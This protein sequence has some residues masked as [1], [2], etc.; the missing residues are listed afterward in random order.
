MHAVAKDSEGRESAK[1]TAF[2]TLVPAN[3]FIGHYTP[4][5]G[6]TVG[7]GMP[8]SINFTR[9]ITDPDAVEKGIKVTHQAVEIEGHWFG[10][11]RLDFRPEK[12]WKPGTEVTV[13]LNLDGVDGQAG[14]LRPAG[15]DGEVHHRP[16]P[17]L[18]RRRRGKQTTIERN[19]FSGLF[20]T[21]D[22]ER[23]MRSFVEEGPGKATFR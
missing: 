4:E 17:G 12:Y 5:D 9:G 19:W 23:G 16:Q 2:T 18:H 7:V 20:A 22:R 15:Q 10:N 6:S 1:D 21:E 14:R 3:T 13:E 11:D 8:V